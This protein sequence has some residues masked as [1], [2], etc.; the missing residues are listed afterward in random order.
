MGTALAVCRKRLQLRSQHVMDGLIYPSGKNRARR[1]FSYKVA[2]A[3][4][5]LQPFVVHIGLGDEQLGAEGA[6]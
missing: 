4:K 2:K 6:T 3:V 5:L 1:V